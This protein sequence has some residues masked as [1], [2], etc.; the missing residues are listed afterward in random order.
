MR[1]MCA[2]DGN[3]H[4][5]CYI[6]D[7]IGI[8]ASDSGGSLSTQRIICISGEFFC[9]FLI[10]GPLIP[11]L[12]FC[13]FF[14]DVLADHA[15]ISIL[16]VVFL[17]FYLIAFLLTCFDC[18]VMLPR[19]SSVDWMAMAVDGVCWKII[20]VSECIQLA[21]VLLDILA[22]LSTILRIVMV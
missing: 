9:C 1:S 6:P 2:Q 10:P 5:H 4:G 20:L 16:L 11:L 15:L 7:I 8:Q 18:H 13:Q 12:G 21:G 22:K 19:D 14:D 17:N 3:S